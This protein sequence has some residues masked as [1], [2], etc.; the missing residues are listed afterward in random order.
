MFTSVSYS[1]VKQTQAQFHITPFT[2]FVMALTLVMTSHKMSTVCKDLLRHI[3]LTMNCC[4]LEHLQTS[5]VKK[6][7]KLSW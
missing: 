5:P 2:P 6:Y 1:K 4:C 7:L 3:Y